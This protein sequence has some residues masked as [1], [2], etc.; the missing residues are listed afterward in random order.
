MHFTTEFR[1]CQQL[2]DYTHFTERETE[3]QKSLA[4]CPS[5]R[6]SR[7]QRQVGQAVCSR[8]WAPFLHAVLLR[9]C[10]WLSSYSSFFLLSCHWVLVIS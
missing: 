8:A 6:A 4:T 3:A 1:S 9:V 7:R 10:G 5:S 2:Y